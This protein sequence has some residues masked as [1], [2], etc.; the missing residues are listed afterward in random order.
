MGYKL[1]RL[2]KKEGKI[3]IYFVTNPGF[4]ATLVPGWGVIIP[5]LGKNPPISG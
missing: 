4:V 3:E 5:G 2:E 1:K